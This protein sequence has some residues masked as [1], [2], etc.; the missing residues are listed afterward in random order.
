[1]TIRKPARPAVLALAPL[2]AAP[3]LLAG[4]SR[5]TL[6]Q[7]DAN[8]GPSAEVPASP[9]VADAAYNRCAAAMEAGQT[10]QSVDIMTA[11]IDAGQ[12]PSKTVNGRCLIGAARGGSL[13]AAMTLGDAFGKAIAAHTAAAARND[14]FGREVAW[15]RLAAA[16]GNTEAEMRLG[17]VLDLDPAIVLPD[18]SF[19]Y[20]VR[21]ARHG[22]LRGAQAIA[23]AYAGG[24][25]HEENMASF[26]L[27]LDNAALRNPALMPAARTLHAP[28]KPMLG[29]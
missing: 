1:M 9:M 7:P 22:D 25:L 10:A 12:M 14:L 24:R 18:E 21:A 17:G 29:G 26:R 28:H 13:M 19:T 27:W 5:P 23:D 6:P 20:Y 8:A 16:H 11:E 4:C 15:Y 3:L 2:L